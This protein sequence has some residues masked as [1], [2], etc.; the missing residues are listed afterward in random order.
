[1]ETEDTIFAAKIRHSHIFLGLTILAQDD[2][3]DCRYG[4]RASMR[5]SMRSRTCS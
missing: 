3:F 2:P 1:M 5:A 4:A